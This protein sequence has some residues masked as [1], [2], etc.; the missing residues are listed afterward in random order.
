[1]SAEIEQASSFSPGHP[2]AQHIVRFS[3]LQNCVSGAAPRTVCVCYKLP[4]ML[5][6]AISRSELRRLLFDVLRTDSDLTGF[7]LDYFPE[8]QRKLSGGMAR[9]A[10]VNLLIESEEVSKI[11]EALALAFPEKLRFSQQAHGPDPIVLAIPL[12]SQNSTPDRVALHDALC[13]M[14]PAEFDKVVFLL[15]VDTALLAGGGTPRS[16]LAT[17]LVKFHEREGADGLIRLVAAIQ[18]TAPRL[19]RKGQ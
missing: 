16:T 7:L 19:L 17:E 2:G 10:K 12:T 18:K 8:V 11:H 14:L 1:M 6:D 15:D 3:N 5:G 13:R 4:T 9:D